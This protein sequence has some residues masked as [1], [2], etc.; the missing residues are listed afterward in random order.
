[1]PGT[2]VSS[3]SFAPA[4]RAGIGFAA[5]IAAGLKSRGVKL[6]VENIAPIGT[7]DFPTKAKRP[8]NSR[9]DLSRLKEVFGIVTPSWIDALAVELDELVMDN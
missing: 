9:L 1:L 4:K 3:T 2:A 5:A 7:Q 8:G 6:E